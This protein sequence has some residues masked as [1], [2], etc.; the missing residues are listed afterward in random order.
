MDHT[1]IQTVNINHQ[2]FF[3]K[4]RKQTN[5]RWNG[6]TRNDIKYIRELINEAEERKNEQMKWRQSQIWIILM[7]CYQL[8]ATFNANVTSSQQQHSLT[9]K[10]NDMY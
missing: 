6:E 1:Q 5:K 8:C 7:K 10:E 3:K 2:Q 9:N 4:K